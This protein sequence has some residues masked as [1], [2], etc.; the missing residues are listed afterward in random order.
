MNSI[1]FDQHVW[2]ANYDWHMSRVVMLSEGAVP[3]PLLG[4]EL[5]LARAKGWLKVGPFEWLCP[6][7]A[8]KVR[9]GIKEQ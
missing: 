9:G 1:T 7:C 8:K 5:S 4:V 3:P 6:E 2:C